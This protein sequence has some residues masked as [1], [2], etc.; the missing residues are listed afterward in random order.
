MVMK[1]VKALKLIAGLTV[2][3]GILVSIP[4]VFY[5]K[6]LPYAVSN[7]KVINYAQTC[8]KKFADIDLKVQEPVLKTAMSP[9]IGFK[10]KNLVVSKNSKNLLA[11][12]NFN[13]EFSFAEILKKTVVVNKLTAEAIFADIDGLMTL[14]PQ[15][16]EEKPKQKS[17]WTIDLFDSLLGVR[18]CLFL[19]TM[20]PDTHLKIHGEHIGI[21]NAI[22]TR[23][24]VRFNFDTEITKG[25][26]KVLLAI[27]DDDK[28]YIENKAIYVDNCPLIINNSKMFFNADAHKD[29]TFNFEV[30]TKDFEVQNVITLL[31]TQIV[32]NNLD[33]I[34]QYFADIKGKF[35]FN[36]K[37]TN[38]SMNGSVDLKN[39]AFKVIPVDN[40]P[41]TLQKGHIT[42]NAKDMTLTGFEG[43]YDNRSV[44]KFKLE[45]T[46]KDYLKS[47]DTDIKGHA[48]ATNDFFK[49]HISAM[50]NYPIELTGNADAAINLKAKNNII[51]LKGV[52]ILPREKNITIG[53][54]PLPFSKATRALTADLHFEDMM[55]DI[56]SIK[57]YMESK[58]AERDA[59]R[60]IFTL[61]G[62]I[63]VAKNN[64]VN[65]VG[66]EIPD[67]LPSEFLN[68]ILKQ[69][70][71]RKGTIAGTM[72]VDNTG[73]YPILDGNMKAE[74]IIIPS[75]RIFLKSG[76]FS[77]NNGLI[78]LN[79]FG[80]YKRSNYE[81]TGNIVNAIKF[82]IVIKD[83]NLSL[84]YLDVYKAITAQNSPQ[85]TNEVAVSYDTEN[86]DMGEGSTD[87]DIGN[88]IIERCNFALKK[89]VYKDINF[90][91]LN[92]TMSLDKNSILNLDSNKFDIAEGYSSVKV[93]CDLKKSKYNLRLGV[94]NVDSDKIA[95]SLLNLKREISGKASGLIDIST[96]NSLKLDGSIRFLIK[97]GTI[98][99]VGLV[100]YIMKVA[101]LFRNPLTMISPSTFSDLVNI[102]EGNFD[103]ING[104]IILKDNVIE[105]MKI[106]SSSPQLS[107][108]IAGRYDLEAKDASLR[109]YTKFSSY[110][111][112]FAGAL[113]NI[114]LNSLANRMSMSSNNDA[115]YY[116]AELE[117]IPPIEADDKDAQIF[118]TKVEGDV[119]HNNFLSS[120][121]KIK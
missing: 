66:F 23:R 112:G 91:N 98:Q 104:E 31:Q 96:D 15:Q 74:K 117:Q 12:K 13:S 78:H 61:N 60:P 64:Y 21:N 30:F 101:A 37:L 111:K 97:N 87:F 114:S 81:F 48:V 59:R 25:N 90:G 11:V 38:N 20:E 102:P 86:V 105:M 1:N 103:K 115:N 53:G 35:D 40:I 108:Y 82:P 56:N 110:K 57:Y 46:V 118:L 120:L 34:L 106:K 69:R 47:I 14:V 72:S 3:A 7:T 44:N 80:K 17:E 93:N 26:K 28:I 42:L 54:E 18:E 39:I 22:K 107:S 16:K 19:Y 77:T 5:L 83:V 92:A 9:V 36:I 89:G 79:A 45:G 29:K 24:F 8:A 43:I 95:S 88:L 63:D 52:F 51:D 27:K 70:F 116:A 41:I 49:Q 33:E 6:V 10:V 113:R 4:F 73:A 32:A 71:F 99:K 55:L 75:Q 100:E 85:Q 67:P 119:E 68:A 121:K 58:N 76:E 62:Q 109:I 84:D 65:K 50:V 2:T 94:V